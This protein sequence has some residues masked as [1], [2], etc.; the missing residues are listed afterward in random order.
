M[1][2][3]VNE[4]KGRAL[5]YRL[6]TEDFASLRD[7]FPYLSATELPRK[8]SLIASL[9]CATCACDVLIVIG[10]QD[11][12]RILLEL[13]QGLDKVIVAIP[14]FG[15]VA[16][17]EQIALQAQQD[18]DSAMSDSERKALSAPWHKDSASGYILAAERLFRRTLPR[19]LGHDQPI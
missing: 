17:T 18:F 3:G 7:R 10:G 19:D 1:L 11:N 2:N 16:V 6:H 15:G 9:A 4:K 14:H 5:I 13:A 8:R 12:A